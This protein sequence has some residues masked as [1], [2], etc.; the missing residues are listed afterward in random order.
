[1]RE[2]HPTGSTWISGG[3]VSAGSV[4]RTDPG[5]SLPTDPVGGE[6]LTKTV[7]YLLVQTAPGLR[8]I[9]KALRAV[10]GVVFASD[11]RGPCAH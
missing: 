11:V 4:T 10:P 9:A 6:A 8:G 1:V 7:A 2:T 3:G 5:R